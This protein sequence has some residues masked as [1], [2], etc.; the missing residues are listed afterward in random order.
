M[1]KAKVLNC[2][3]KTFNDNTYYKL[4]VRCESCVGFVNSKVAHQE[5][6]EVE[7]SLGTTKDSKFFLRL[8]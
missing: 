2:E 3:K 5:G 4:L 7:L 8:S 6:T 1:L